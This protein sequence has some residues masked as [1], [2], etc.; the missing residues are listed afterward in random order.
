MPGDFDPDSDSCQ[1]R[2]SHILPESYGVGP[3]APNL[4]RGERA[5]F[6]PGQGRKPG[7]IFIRPHLLDGFRV[8]DQAVNGTMVIE[9]TNWMDEINRKIKCLGIAATSSQTLP[10][11][12]LA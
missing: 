10:P 9:M 1:K 6:S 8:I 4:S 5:I 11:G 2:F 7:H 12:T 3:T